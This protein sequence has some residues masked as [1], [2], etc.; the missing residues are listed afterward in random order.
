MGYLAWDGIVSLSLI[1]IG[2]ILLINAEE[3]I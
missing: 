1:D 3:N 2:R